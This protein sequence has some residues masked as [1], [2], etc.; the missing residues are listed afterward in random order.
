MPSKG[1]VTHLGQQRGSERKKK[2]R[3]A[4]WSAEHQRKLR[5]LNW[6]Q[7][8]QDCVDC[9]IVIRDI[10]SIT[11]STDWKSAFSDTVRIRSGVEKYFGGS[12]IKTLDYLRVEGDLDSASFEREALSALMSLG[13]QLEELEVEFSDGRGKYVG[14]CVWYKD[15]PSY[16]DAKLL[17]QYETA[18]PEGLSFLFSKFKTEKGGDFE[19]SLMSTQMIAAVLFGQTGPFLFHK[20][21]IFHKVVLSLPPQNQAKAA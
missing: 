6:A 3:E 11:G 1:K 9:E 4:K 8:L 5:A 13:Y 16:H 2:L 21:L 12:V 18:T 14:Q 20:T 10:E 15:H 7:D 19:F 17:A